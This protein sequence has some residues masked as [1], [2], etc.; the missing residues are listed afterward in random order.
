MLEICDEVVGRQLVSDVYNW[1]RLN[2]IP[3]HGFVATEYS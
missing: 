1:T 2:L 3:R